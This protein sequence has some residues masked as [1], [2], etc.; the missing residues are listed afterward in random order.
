MFPSPTR[1]FLTKGVGVHRHALT[2]FEFALRD[3]DIEQQN[4]VY[5]SSI[6]P[7]HCELITRSAGVAALSPGEITFSVLARAYANQG[8]LTE[9]LL[10]T[11][12]WLDSNRVE[13]AAHY[14]HAM[15]LQE[16][17]EW[18]DAR[19]ALQ[20]AV[21]LQPDFALA[22]FALGNLAR[23]D[24]RAA[25]ANK[26]FANALRSLRHRSPDEPLPDSDGMTVGR[27]VQTITA[28][29]SIPGRPHRAGGRIE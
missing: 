10:W 3:A 14:L 24:G 18:R 21:Y 8:N 12:R 25:E 27:L 23:A 7:P 11:A 17:G 16:K 28:L 1:V 13:P 15:I 22:D 5:V 29:A 4:L 6:L 26:H 19:R 2:A 20:S 9:A